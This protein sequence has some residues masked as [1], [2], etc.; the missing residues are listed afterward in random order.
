MTESLRAERSRDAVCVSR[1]LCARPRTLVG[2][3]LRRWLTPAFLAAALC[4]RAA[5]LIV[6]NVQD[7]GPGSLR[8]AIAQAADGDSIR[9]NSALSGQIIPLMTGSILLD[10]SLTIDASDL[11][12]GIA[13]S[14][15]GMN[16]IFEITSAGRIT[17]RSLSLRD[18]HAPDGTSDGQG[19]GTR[20]ESGGAVRNEG[21]LTLVGC[22]LFDNSAG[23][24]GGVA[25]ARA[26]GGGNGGAI[27]N[28]GTLMMTNCTLSGNAAG[29]RGA[30]SAGFAGFGGAVFNAGTASVNACTIANNVVPQRDDG[31]AGFAAIQDARPRTPNDEGI[32][33]GAAD[34]QPPPGALASLPTVY[35]SPSG[36]DSNAGTRSSPLLTAGAALSAIGG[37]GEVVLLAGDYQ[38]LRFNMAAATR[39]TIRADIG[40]VVRVFL[41]EKV[42]TFSHDSGTVWKAAVASGYDFTEADNRR[43]VFEWGTPEGPI[44]PAA[45]QPLQLGRTHRLLH[46]RLRVQPNKAAVG[47]GPGRFWYD[48]VDH[49]LYISATD[50]GNP[51]GRDYWIPSQTSLQS[52]VFGGTGSTDVVVEGVHVFFGRDNLNFSYCRSYVARACQL[53]GASDEGIT[54]NPMVRG[55][56]E[57]NEYAANANDG[58][59]PANYFASWASLEVVDPWAHDNGDEGHSIHRNIAASYYGGLYEYNQSGGITPALGASCTAYGPFTRGNFVGIYPAVTILNTPLNITSISATNPAVITTAAVH[60]LANG[61]IVRIAG[62][63]GSIPDMNGDRAATVLSPT[64][65]SVALSQT[66]VP[67]GGTVARLTGTSGTFCDWVSE[68]DH[69]SAYNPT[70]NGVLKLISPR[71]I[72]PV[73]RAFNA[74]FGSTIEAYDPVLISVSTTTGGPGTI[75]L[76]N[77]APIPCPISE[78]GA[79]LFS[80]GRLEIGNSIVAANIGGNLGNFGNRVDLGSNITSG[81]PRLAPLADYGGPAPTMAL[82]PD[83]PARNTAIT[84]VT[85]T[86]Q[87]GFSRPVGPPDIGAYEAG[88]EA[89]FRA[90]V[91]EKLPGDSD[92]AFSA[93]HDRDGQSEGLEYALRSDPTIPAGGLVSFGRTTVSGDAASAITFP[94]R[95]A[96]R[97]LTYRI[98]RTLD[99]TEE[100]GWQEIL[101]LDLSTGAI[102]ESG[103]VTALFDN[104]AGMATVFDVN[105]VPVKAFWRLRVDQGGASN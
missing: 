38:N 97:D 73:V 46:S 100:N 2:R 56:E 89:G 18:G 85:P 47:A 41:G 61:E 81:D 59:G 99:L 21:M 102:T 37:A 4:V 96:A 40:A 77:G 92:H 44:A 25:P 24:G 13:I 68:F 27:F 15:G 60:G 64:S 6:T 42:S 57:N 91:F 76:I 51:N 34:S 32:L 19:N 63:T 5:D 82:L 7:S 9:F 20:G 93:D 43:W 23:D 83:S 95:P 10:K 30:G 33:A 3:S 49:T 8:M 16:R 17:F 74:G 36:N 78:S 12:K 29:N 101:R 88:N 26:G 104:L 54:A 90:W 45:A 79:G 14:G 67:A 50:G 69:N 84:A 58:S 39:L 94:Y 48:S 65:F 103:G 71:V 35:L 53:F 31:W 11:P 52:F 70:I 98:E 87:R 72:S 80:G 1:F 66:G 22:T 75:L 62:V 105:A 28:R 55:L 86:D